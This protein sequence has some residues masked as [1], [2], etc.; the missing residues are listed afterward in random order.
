MSKD[1]SSSKGFWERNPLG[2][3]WSEN[4]RVWPGEEP[5]RQVLAKICLYVLSV[6]KVKEFRWC[7]GCSEE[8]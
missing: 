7:P 4:V 6:K 3:S 2:Q 5:W 1:Y 8:P